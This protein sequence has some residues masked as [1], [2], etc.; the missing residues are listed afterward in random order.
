MSKVFD[1][2]I[3]SETSLTRRDVPDSVY[4]YFSALHAV[5]VYRVTCL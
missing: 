1:T 5:E 3:I 4:A 2:Q